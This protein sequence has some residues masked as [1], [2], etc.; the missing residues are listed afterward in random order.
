MDDTLE[1]I[2]SS[3][4]QTLTLD[5]LQRDRDLELAYADLYYEYFISS[6]G[7]VR[8]R[9]NI[10]HDLVNRG[11]YCIQTFSD[12]LKAREETKY[13]G[14]DP[15]D[16]CTQVVNM[17]A[18]WQHELQTLSLMFGK[19]T[20]DPRVAAAE[21]NWR[22]RSHTKMYVPFKDLIHILDNPK[23]VWRF[24]TQNYEICLD[25]LTGEV[26]KPYFL[27]RASDDKSCFM[28]FFVPAPEE[29]IFEDV[30]G[31][32][33]TKTH[34]KVLR[35]FIDNHTTNSV[36]VDSCVLFD[37]L[38][39]SG[40]D[41]S[42]CTSVRETFYLILT[43][44]TLKTPLVLLDVDY[45]AAMERPISLHAKVFKKVCSKR[46]YSFEEFMDSCNQ[47][48]N[49][50]EGIST[51][52]YK[53]GDLS[54][55]TEIITE[56]NFNTENLLL[57]LE[58]NSSDSISEEFS[59]IDYKTEISSFNS[60]VHSICGSDLVVGDTDEK[61]EDMAPPKS[62]WISIIIWFLLEFILLSISS[63]TNIICDFITVLLSIYAL[64]LELEVVKTFMILSNEFNEEKRQLEVLRKCH[65]MKCREVMDLYGSQTNGVSIKVRKTL[66]GV[67][68]K[69]QQ[70][71]KR[72]VK[73]N[74]LSML[75]K[76]VWGSLIGSYQ[77]I[78]GNIVKIPA[79]TGILILKLCFT[80]IVV[81]VVS[82]F[83]DDV[84][85]VATIFQRPPPPPPPPPLFSLKWIAIHL[86][87]VSKP[88]PPPP[89]SM[90][91][92]MLI[93]IT[94]L[95]ELICAS[96]QN[97]S[98]SVTSSFSQVL[99]PWKPCGIVQI[100]QYTRAIRVVCGLALTFARHYHM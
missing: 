76:S 61:I 56:D 53:M 75:C 5:S 15:S 70:T 62:R 74:F 3:S 13:Y 95:W 17:L 83:W 44:S 1:S 92:L 25:N 35:K 66:A 65:L 30:S 4:D 91:Q 89:P 42:G 49:I 98:L 21:K 41:L 58:P 87:L 80:L 54:F 38:L 73:P 28:P 31:E 88:P 22:I 10:K 47:L 51:E 79:S 39:W 72:L 100:V 90:F 34:Q 93:E 68:F 60:S 18:I 94:K 78:K 57:E 52:D 81:L 14:L 69:L 33:F 29:G 50:L 63:V 45:E 59:L 71:E 11:K 2:D 19:L 24:T 26:C 43:G 8:N 36:S 64:F 16:L 84:M 37:S 23:D 27:V 67:E 77:F 85:K 55:S 99:F 96:L 6:K 46:D 86:R 82:H 7:R 40:Y 32:E 20:G 97:L 48:D 9:F 12:L